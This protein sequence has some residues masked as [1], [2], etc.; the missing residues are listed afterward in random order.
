VY[1]VGTAEGMTDVTQLTRT[2]GLGTAVAVKDATNVLGAAY[3]P[4]GLTIVLVRA[5]ATTTVQRN[6]V[7]GQFQL[8]D[9]LRELGTAGQGASPQPGSAAS[10]VPTPT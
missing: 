6:L 1:L 5:D 10:V 4:A 9:R 8:T 2:A 7:A 3:H